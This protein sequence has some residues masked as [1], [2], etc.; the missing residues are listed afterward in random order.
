M[1]MTVLGRGIVGF[2][3]GIF[4][5]LCQGCVGHVHMKDYAGRWVLKRSGQDLIVLN[6]HARHRHLYGTI[7]Q[8]ARFKEQ[9]WGQILDIS[10]ARKTRPVS[11]TAGRWMVMLKLGTGKDVDRVHAELLPN[12]QKL[13]I[14]WFPPEYV[15]ELVFHKEKP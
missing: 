15:T 4:L 3:G 12:K 1:T 9:G 8:P 10:K 11:G 13:A 2:L 5:V 6:M 14:A 7:T